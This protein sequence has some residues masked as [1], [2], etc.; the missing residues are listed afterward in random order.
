VT[1]SR[2]R[3]ARLVGLLSL[4][5]AAGAWALHEGFSHVSDDDYARV[6]I[7]ERFAH[8]PSFDPSGTSWLPCPFWLQGTA[9][10]ALGRTLSTAHAVAWLSGLASVLIGYAGLR[11]ASVPRATAWV[12]TA[13]VATSPWNTW[14][15]VATVPEAVTAALAFAGVMTM[16]SPRWRLTGALALFLAA[17]SR[18][19]AWPVCGCFAA[20]SL[21]AAVR[22]PS[23]ERR[24]AL[25]AAAIALAG[26]C[27][28]MAWNAHA[29]GSPVHFLTRV[30]AFH[31]RHA[32]AIP[33][34][35]RLLAYPRALVR[36]APEI[37][38]L[39]A[40]G[41]LGG[42]EA[43][44]RWRG[45]LR[46][47]GLVLA[48]LEVGEIVGGAPT[49]HAERALVLVW[50][51][52]GGFGVDGVRAF[53]VRRAWARP[54]REAWAVAL[55]VVATG[56]I[57]GEWLDRMRAHPA[58]APEEDRTAQVAR[59]L[60]LRADDTAAV[61]VVPCAY[62]HFALMAAFGAPERVT[63]MPATGQPVTAACPEVVR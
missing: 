8:A 13:L 17:L 48:F 6:V 39:G 15:G 27:L 29:H 18:Y 2:A 24:R 12:V 57:V 11:A 60:S 34:A 32:A 45:P 55:A 61:T 47:T 9:M 19:E 46:T 20:Q 3:V 50:W 37:V 14:L 49:H 16:S 22:A 28:W 62:E 5:A 21:V 33:L 1:P 59:G 63:V 44:A 42:V 31:E 53:V 30:A 43:R 4:K 52:L 10:L 51:V 23:V 26:P 38:A 58:A 41:L 36:G 56:A 54:K 35:E 25:V 7:A 40:L